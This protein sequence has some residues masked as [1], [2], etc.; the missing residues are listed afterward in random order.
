MQAYSKCKREKLKEKIRIL[1]Y[2]EQFK[3]QVHH[4]YI[5]LDEKYLNLGD[6]V[7]VFDNP[8]HEDYEYKENCIQFQD[9]LRDFDKCFD[10]DSS[11]ESPDDELLRMAF[12]NV[13]NR[14]KQPPSTFKE[15]ERGF[16]L[17]SANKQKLF[18][19]NEHGTQVRIKPDETRQM[20]QGGF[21]KYNAT[22]NHWERTGEKVSDVATLFRILLLY[23]LSMHAGFF[24]RQFLSLDGT[25]IYAVL[26]QELRNLIIEAQRTFLKKRVSIAFCDIL[27]LEPVDEAFRPLRFN[28]VIRSKLVGQDLPFESHQKEIRKLLKIIDYNKLARECNQ[29]PYEIS[30]E[31]QQQRRLT[32][33]VLNAYVFYLEQ[34]A[35]DLI[36]VRKKYKENDFA[37]ILTSQ[38]LKELVAD[39]KEQ[40]FKSKSTKF[41][42]RE[43]SKGNWK[44]TNRRKIKVFLKRKMALEIE[45]ILHNAKHQTDK[46]YGRKLL[47]IW[48]RLGMEPQGPFIEYFYPRKKQNYNKFIQQDSIW[49]YQ[50]INE[51]GER[52][53]FNKMERAKLNISILKSLVNLEYLSS[54]DYIRDHLIPNSYFD[55]DG[56]KYKDEHYQPLKQAKQQKQDL[57]FSMKL[58][59]TVK[60]KIQK[61]IQK[62]QNELGEKKKK[63]LTEG[64][65][66]GDNLLNLWG[67]LD[68]PVQHICSYYGERIALYFMFLQFFVHELLPISYFGILTFIVQIL[69]DVEALANKV[70]IIFFTIMIVFWSS[71]FQ[72]LWIR[73]EM[74]F[75]TMFG[76][77]DMELNQV[78]LIGFVG[79]PKRSIANDKLNDLQY[80]SKETWFK[81]FFNMIL[82]AIFLVIEIVIIVALQLLSLYLENNPD[83][84]NIEFI[85]LSV[86]I[87]ALIWVFIGILLDNIYR[88][89]AFFLTKWENHK[90]LSQFET[91]FIIKNLLFS[92]VNRLGQPFIIA[93]FYEQTIGCVNDNYCYSQLQIYMRVVFIIEFGKHILFGFIFPIIKQIYQR[94]RYGFVSIVD[95]GGSLQKKTPYYH[96][97]KSIEA[98]TQKESFTID[99]VDGTIWEYLELNLQFALLANFGSP[100]P[101][102]FITG[103]AMNYLELFLDK[104]K[105]IWLTKR[106]TPQTAR[107]IGPF[108]YYM[109]LISYISIFINSG[110]LSYSNQDVFTEINSF[111]LFA[112]LMI[113]FFLFKFVTDIIY[114]NTDSSAELVRQR[115][116]SIQKRLHVSIRG[117]NQMSSKLPF[118][119]AKIY[120][121]LLP[122]QLKKQE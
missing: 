25:K 93:F 24:I 39:L 77:E 90:Y 10:V 72:A 115:H 34:I 31:I 27:S 22:T 120:G 66:N 26:F 59:Q 78:E 121:T 47:S 58:I 75:Q 30:G 122:H 85:E 46:L 32:A 104:F 2:P 71:T 70:S 99:Q 35:S 6:Y 67:L 63:V 95:F 102:I 87:P 107:T 76:L 38:E 81:F 18:I 105:L 64:G 79:K 73:Q 51:K 52:S 42:V 108:V 45:Q 8:D 100:F 94:A 17:S 41:Y 55:L 111:T 65:L 15:I 97:N 82:V 114:G 9:V 43:Q 92:T 88:P 7:L 33:D 5:V 11:F 3:P 28:K 56:Q 13:F 89:V 110:L 44:D 61:F 20:G 12:L 19:V 50:I 103:L 68:V 113:A 37:Q 14:L 49:T 57:F 4:N 29:Y 1:Q 96:F 106:P 112:I 23:K 98:E 80:S 48:D 36:N 54:Q 40:N 119:I 117:K 91:S 69:Y 16:Q 86:F 74:Q 62:D 60:A 84:P 109:N 21:L 53:L 83:V 116:Q 101:L 118:P